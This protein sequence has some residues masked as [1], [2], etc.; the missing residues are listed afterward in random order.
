MDVSSCSCYLS[1]RLTYEMV[2]GISPLV[3]FVFLVA[4]FLIVLIAAVV[5]AV[6]ERTMPIDNRP[7]DTDH[8]SEE[9]QDDEENSHGEFSNQRS[10]L[11]H[12]AHF[13]PAV[14]AAGASAVA[15]LPC[16]PWLFLRRAALLACFSS[17]MR[18]AFFSV[19]LAF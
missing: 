5:I 10:K 16:L 9:G 4:L 6:N 11:A 8:R 3:F 15:A 7:D 17:V 1:Y 19:R 13:F 14:A 12:D 2:L 18:E